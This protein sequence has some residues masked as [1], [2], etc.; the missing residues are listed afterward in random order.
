MSLCLC[1]FVSLCLCIVCVL[2]VCVAVTDAA[3]GSAGGAPV[4]GAAALKKAQRAGNAELLRLQALQA[5]ANAVAAEEVMKQDGAVY[6]YD[7][8]AA[9]AEGVQQRTQGRRGG[10]G[11]SARSE[12]YAKSWCSAVCGL[13]AA[14]ACTRGVRGLGRVAE[15]RKPKPQA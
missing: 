3:S 15:T 13:R 1:A 10:Y 5:K 9:S 8:W 7:S 11:T 2:C 6:D 12:G 4:S 14:D